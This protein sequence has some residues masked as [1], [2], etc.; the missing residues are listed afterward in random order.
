MQRPRTATARFPTAVDALEDDY[1]GLD[2]LDNDWPDH[3]F[4]LVKTEDE[5]VEP[6][7]VEPTEAVG[8]VQ[9]GEEEAVE[10]TVD[11]GVVKTEVA[12]EVKSEIIVDYSATTGFLSII[13]RNY[14]SLYSST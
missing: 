1:I 6:T 10:P 2:E 11:V 5:E 13:T 14:E 9:T 3:S 4:D 12:K 7:E 8:A